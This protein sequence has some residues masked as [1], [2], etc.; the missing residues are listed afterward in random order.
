MIRNEIHV[1]IITRYN[2]D[3]S[4]TL[5][6]YTTKLDHPRSKLPLTYKYLK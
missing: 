6:M 2:N 1:V 4:N 3:M 5:A